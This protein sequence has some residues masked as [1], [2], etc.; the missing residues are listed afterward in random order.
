MPWR[1]LLAFLAMPGIVA[2]AIPAWMA[3]GALRSGGRV[4][5][6]GLLPLLTGFALL[7]WCVR[8]FYVAGKG[9]LAPWSPP[10]RLVTVGLYRLSRNPMYIAVALMLAGWAIAFA[11]WTMAIYAGFVMGAFQ[12]R[13]V[14]GEEPWLART[15]GAAWDEYRARVPRWLV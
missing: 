2:V 3:A 1:A 4:H 6:V 10:R 8:D 5:P 15:H 11:S 9:T 7:V 14:Y 13:V 12:L